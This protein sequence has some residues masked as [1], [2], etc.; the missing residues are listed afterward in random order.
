MA[1]ALYMTVAAI[2]ALLIS[3]IPKHIPSGRRL[4]GSKFTRECGHIC[5]DYQLM[6]YS[7]HFGFDIFTKAKSYTHISAI[8]H[9]Q[10]K[11]Y[12]YLALRLN[13][14]EEGET[15]AILR[16]INLSPVRVFSNKRGD[17]VAIY[18]VFTRGEVT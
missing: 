15:A 13:K 7:R 9:D 5:H 11:Q 14:R 6:Y 10:W 8:A 4:A 2:T 3:A 12:D 17:R 1:A 18:R 16:E